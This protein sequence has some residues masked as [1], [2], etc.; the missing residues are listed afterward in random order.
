VRYAPRALAEETLQ[1][2]VESALA[3]PDA[4]HAAF[5]SLPAPIYVTDAAGLVTYFNTACVGFTGRRP[6]VGKDRWCVA[7]KLFT[8]EGE[9]LPHDQCPMA[10]AIKDR[11]PIRGV[12]AV[13]ERP[14]GTRVSFMPFPTPIHG[15]DG[16]LV[17]AVNMLI[18]ITELRQAAEL[19]A[20]AERARRLMK[21]I[22]DSLTRDALRSFADECEAQAKALESRAPSPY[23]QLA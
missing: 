8:S 1:C 22:T 17:G 10:I 15:A 2:A 5:E 11:R 14:D 7:W 3:G 18:D 16:E 21:S 13:A 6:A 23:V 20:E 12:T 4:L 19:R 9:P